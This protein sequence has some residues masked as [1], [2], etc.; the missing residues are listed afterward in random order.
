M[1][2][3]KKLYSISEENNKNVVA[4]YFGMGGGNK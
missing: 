4:E 3:M 1:L 2:T